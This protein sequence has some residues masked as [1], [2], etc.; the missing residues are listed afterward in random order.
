MKCYQFDNIFDD[1]DMLIDIKTELKK[2]NIET[3]ESFPENF[4]FKHNQIMKC[5]IIRIPK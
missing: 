5:V 1:F 4:S 2:L 3:T